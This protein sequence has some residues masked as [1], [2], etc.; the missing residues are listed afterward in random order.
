MAARNPS[1]SRHSLAGL[2]RSA[3]S[4][5]RIQVSLN[6]AASPDTLLALTDD[7]DDDTARHAASAL[8]LQGSA[9][10]R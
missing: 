7:E 5:L 6:P 8:L 2:A 4:R 1:N 10:R 9:A 3:E